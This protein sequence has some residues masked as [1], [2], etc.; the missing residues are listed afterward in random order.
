MKLT[1]KIFWGFNG[2]GTKGHLVSTAELF[3]LSWEDLYIWSRAIYWIYIKRRKKWNMEWWWCEPRKYKLKQL[4]IN[5]TPPTPPPKKNKRISEKGMR[6][7]IKTMR[8]T[9]IEIKWRYDLIVALVIEILAR[10]SYHLF[11][12]CLQGFLQN[13]TLALPNPITMTDSNYCCFVNLARSQNR[14][15]AYHEIPIRQE[16][17]NI[18]KLH[19]GVLLISSGWFLFWKLTHN[20]IEELILGQRKCPRKTI[21]STDE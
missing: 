10:L 17:N 12:A 14:F 13:L 20:N 21:W 9:E 19:H 16:I 18:G 1:R 8:T 15:H 3:Q 11:E 2:I 5:P 7:G 4:Q 6:H